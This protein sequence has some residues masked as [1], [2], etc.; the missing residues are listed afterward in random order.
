MGVSHVT[1]KVER[2]V[3]Y[4]KRA[5]YSAKEVRSPTLFAT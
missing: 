3:E 4:V 5:L 2:S 1:G